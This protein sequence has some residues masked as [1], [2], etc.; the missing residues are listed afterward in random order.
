[1]TY[2]YD[3]PNANAPARSNSIRFW[4]YPTRIQHPVGIAV[5]TAENLP[6]WDGD[7]TGAEA[8]ARYMSTMTRPASY[9]TVVDSDSTIECLPASGTAFHVKGWNSSLLGLAFATQAAAWVDAPA[10]WVTAILNRGADVAADWCAKFEIE[11]KHVTPQILDHGGTGLVGHGELDPDRRTDPGAGFPWERFL[12]LVTDRLEPVGPVYPEPVLAAPMTF[13]DYHQTAT[14]WAWW[15]IADG[16]IANLGGAP[17]YGH[18]LDP[19]TVAILSAELGV[20]A[21]DIRYEGNPVSIVGNTL[22]GYTIW[23]DTGNSYNFWRGTI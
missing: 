20:P 19:R 4:G 15:L 14:G 10:G 11:A 17:Y 8:V 7:D 5:H 16:G 22:G 3:H 2:L 21:A 9:H 6:D 13:V 1:M 12:Q 18:L 23:C